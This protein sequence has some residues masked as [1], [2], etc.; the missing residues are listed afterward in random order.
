MSS[1]A[2]RVWLLSATIL[3]THSLAAAEPGTS[4]P[5]PAKAAELFQE[6]LRDYDRGD[7]ETAIAKLRQ[8]QAAAPHPTVLY[9]L[10]QF[11]E[12][13]GHRAEAVRCFEQ[14]LTILG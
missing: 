1:V 10:A 8:A 14:Y 9:N 6:A 2:W 11:L 5:A 13:A 12:V 7:L 3:A 4:E